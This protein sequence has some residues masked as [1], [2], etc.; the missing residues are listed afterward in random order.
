[1]KQILSI[2]TLCVFL[3]MLGMNAN[4]K[5][6]QGDIAAV[7]TTMIGEMSC[8]SAG[9]KDWSDVKKGQFLYEGDSLFFFSDGVIEAHSKVDPNNDFG[10]EQIEEILKKNHDYHPQIIVHQLFETVYHFI[11]NPDQQKDDMTTVLIE[12]PKE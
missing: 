2:T 3:L 7:I 4:S 5:T 12:F 6:G 9:S 8:K 10:E 1:M 11:G